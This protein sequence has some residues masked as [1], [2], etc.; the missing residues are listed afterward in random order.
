MNDILAVTAAPDTEKHVFPPLTLSDR[1]CAVSS[2]STQALVRVVKG[3]QD[4]LFDKHTFEKFQATL[5]G[6]GWTVYEDIRDSIN[7]QAKP[8]VL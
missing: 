4:L 3:K 6:Q 7:P 1:S 5:I 2:L 8:P